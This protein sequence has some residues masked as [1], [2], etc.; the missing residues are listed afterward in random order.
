MAII[1]CPTYV[2]RC[3]C[4]SGSTVCGTMLGVPWVEGG[5]VCNL[6]VWMVSVMLLFMLIL[7][8]VFRHFPEPY[9]PL[10]LLCLPYTLY[11]LCH[12]DCSWTLPSLF[13]HIIVLVDKWHIDRNNTGHTFNRQDYT[14]RLRWSSTW[15]VRVKLTWSCQLAKCINS[16]EPVQLK[17]IS[18]CIFSPYQYN[19][20]NFS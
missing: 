8:P 2:A 10:W 4:C 9:V 7:F 19:I 5:V 11:M 13:R 1:G 17:V 3:M 15:Q 18:K 20:L 14:C 6:A 12:I 16:V